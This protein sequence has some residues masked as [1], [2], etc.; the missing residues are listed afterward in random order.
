MR[1]VRKSRRSKSKSPSKR[2]L[3]IV[4]I[5][6]VAFFPAT[7]LFPTLLPVSQIS[8]INQIPLGVVGNK[9]ADAIVLPEQISPG[10]PIHLKIPKIQ[11]DTVLE[12]VGLLPNGTVG[13]PKGPAAAGWFNLGPHP[14]DIG[15]AVIAGHY[16]RW[17]NGANS[18]FNN[19]NKLRKGDNLFVVDEN[20]ATTTFVVRESRKYDPNAD[21]SAVFSSNDDKSHLNLITCEG[22]WNKAAK[23]YS[24]RLVVFADR[25]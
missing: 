15:S 10:I 18:V 9:L 1:S 2:S 5:V 16:G 3:F 21:A 19:L 24:G 7:I 11:V 20:G 14:G 8:Q 4:S 13:V 6:G 25:Q 12:Q 17:Q 22:S 23:S